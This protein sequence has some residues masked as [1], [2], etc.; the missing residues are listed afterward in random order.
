M[1][2]GP[3]DE[4]MPEQPLSSVSKGGRNDVVRDL[5]AGTFG[6][7]DAAQGV[8]I[9]SDF[10]P[11]GTLLD[12]GATATIAEEESTDARQAWQEWA[13]RLGCTPDFLMANSY[14]L[15]TLAKEE[16]DDHMQH[17]MSDWFNASVGGGIGAAAGWFVPIPGASLVLGL[18]GSEVGRNFDDDDKAQSK[19]S[20]RDIANAI[21]RKQ[22]YGEEVTADEAFLLA[23]S[24]EDRKRIYKIMRDQIPEGMDPLA[25][26]ERFKGIALDNS[27]MIENK[28]DELGI[29]P[30][31]GEY[32]AEALARA[33]NTPNPANGKKLHPVL[34]LLD[35]P[36][37]VPIFSGQ[38][39]QTGA[40]V[41]DRQMPDA[42]YV[43]P[44]VGYQGKN[45]E[46]VNA[47]N[48][49]ANAM[50]G[51]YRPNFYSGTA[52]EVDAGGYVTPDGLPTQTGGRGPVA[53]KP[54][55]FSHK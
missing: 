8:K 21:E 30:E 34:V 44:N 38:G 13:Q 42:G 32:A 43:D 10:V 50:R 20:V 33:L 7:K 47:N 53:R 19:I 18:I 39:Q 28:L 12:L 3:D 29:I 4:Y 51:A 37:K 5:T 16:T 1:A 24:P 46:V 52:E 27:Y 36:G 11:G 22:Y 31:Q 40:Q 6:T 23:L 45:Q 26:K 54:R 48:A 55:D 17:S 41:S 15:R 9:L 25:A 49:G 14:S 2:Y 35:N